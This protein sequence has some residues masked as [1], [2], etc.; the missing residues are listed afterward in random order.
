M[1]WK[2]TNSNGLLCG[3]AL[4]C[5]TARSSSVHDLNT[6]FQLTR[7]FWTSIRDIPCMQCGSGPEWLTPV[8]TKSAFGG[9]EFNWKDRAS[10]YV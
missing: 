9:I 5:R 3:A 4:H 1:H 7:V 8:I 10:L 6:M 2:V